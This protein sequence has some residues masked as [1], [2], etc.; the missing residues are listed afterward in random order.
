MDLKSDLKPVYHKKPSELFVPFEAEEAV[1]ATVYSDRVSTTSSLKT[2]TTND[3][4]ARYSKTASGMISKLNQPAIR[5]NSGSGSG[6]GSEEEFYVDVEPK[7]GT[8]V[9]FRSDKIEHEVHPPPSPS[10]SLP[11]WSYFNRHSQQYAFSMFCN[12]L[13]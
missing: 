1:E 2:H 5:I 10:P 6:S 3:S 4:S 8:L 11:P 7:F 12:C 13:Q 9:V